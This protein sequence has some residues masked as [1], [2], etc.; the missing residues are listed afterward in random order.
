MKGYG[1]KH[2]AKAF[3]HHRATHHVGY[4]WVPVLFNHV[5]FNEQ[6][7]IPSIQKLGFYLTHV[8]FALTI[9][10]STEPP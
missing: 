3:L 6:G 9:M 1:F 5:S 2:Y 4:N 10:D 8:P 7:D